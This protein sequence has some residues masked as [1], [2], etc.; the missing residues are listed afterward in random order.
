MPWYNQH[1]RWCR[2]VRKK[3]LNMMRPCI[4]NSDEDSATTCP[5]FERVVLV[6]LQ[7]QLVAF[8]DSLQFTDKKEQLLI[9]LF[10]MFKMFFTPGTCIRL[11]C[12]DF[13]SAF[14]TI[15]PHLLSEKLLNMKVH[16][17]TITWI[18]DYLA[19]RLYVIVFVLSL[20][21]RLPKLAWWL[22]QYQIRRWHGIGRTNNWQRWHP[23]PT[24]DW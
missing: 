22:Y 24:G 14:D 16:A 19:N 17:S 12:Y 5:E 21:G 13:S 23:L 7:K 18:L 9:M 11:M 1:R 4:I 2:R 20:Y 6:H 10:Y 15:Q 3:Q 8:V